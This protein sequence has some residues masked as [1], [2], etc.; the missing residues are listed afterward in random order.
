[1][2]SGQPRGSYPQS[3]TPSPKAVKALANVIKQG[4]I[5]KITPDGFSSKQIGECQR[6]S[7][8]D[9]G[10]GAILTGSAPLVTC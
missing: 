7:A 5:A 2:Q 10:M 8:G 6:V 3:A 4:S 9:D 1:M